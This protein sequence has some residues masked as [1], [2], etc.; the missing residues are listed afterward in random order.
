MIRYFLLSNQL[1]FFTRNIDGENKAYKTAKLQKLTETGRNFNELT[2]PPSVPTPRL[3]S[4]DLGHIR[5][6]PTL[7]WSQ[8]SQPHQVYTTTWSPTLSFPAQQHE[9]QWT[10]WSNLWRNS[11]MQHPTLKDSIHQNLCLSPYSTMPLLTYTCI[12]WYHYTIC[13]CS[14]CSVYVKQINMDHHIPS[15]SLPKE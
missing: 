6:S 13:S 15:Y 9:Q 2:Y 1:P 3:H 8:S 7:H 5:V 4:G 14:I 10:R 11:R 12:C